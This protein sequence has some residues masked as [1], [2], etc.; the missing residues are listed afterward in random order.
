MLEN[1]FNTVTDVKWKTKDT[2][3][4]II[5]IALF[6]HRKNMKLVYVGS[7]VTKP[8]GSFVLDKNTRLLVYQ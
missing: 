1:I 6:F 5:D 4:A 8:K 7:W 2:I 3:K